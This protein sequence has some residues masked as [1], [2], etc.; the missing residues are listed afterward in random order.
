[1]KI[2]DKTIFSYHEDKKKKTEVAHFI[3]LPKIAL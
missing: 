1:M 3:N 2:P